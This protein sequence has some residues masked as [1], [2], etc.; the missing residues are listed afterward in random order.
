VGDLVEIAASVLTQAEKRVEV[1]AQNISNATTPSYK[2]AVAFSSLVRASETEDYYPQITTVTDYRAGKLVETGNPYDIAILQDGFFAVRYDDKVAYTRQGQFSANAEGH[3]VNSRGG[4]LQAAGGS[5]FVIDAE[6]FE[7]RTDGFIVVDGRP[8]ARI[9]VFDAEDR[10]ALESVGGELTAGDA[11]MQLVRSMAV[12][13]GA[14]ETSNVTTGDE[15]VLMMEALRR[16]EA[17]QRIMSVYDDLMGRAITS[18][19]DSV[20]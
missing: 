6:Q 4:I 12:R 16:A 17:G 19:G 5:D 1:A 3:L 8:A 7:L 13:Q 2:R 10:S 11:T 18:F 15:M 14:F 20:R 9:G